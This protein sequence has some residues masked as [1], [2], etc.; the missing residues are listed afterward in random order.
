MNRRLGTMFVRTL[1]LLLV[2]GCGV[3]GHALGEFLTDLA[4][5]A[6]AAW[7]L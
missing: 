6:L 5:G 2:G 7:L 3:T 4:R 1:P